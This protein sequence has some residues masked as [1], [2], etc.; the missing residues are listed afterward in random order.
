[1]DDFE[2]FRNVALGA[3]GA[4]AVTAAVLFSVVLRF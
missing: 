3:G 1:M 2:T 4:L